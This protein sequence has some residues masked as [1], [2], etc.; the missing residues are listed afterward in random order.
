LNYGKK[1]KGKRLDEIPVDYLEW[2]MKDGP[3]V[4]QDLRQTIEDFLRPQNRKPHDEDGEIQPRKKNKR[5][6]EQTPEDPILQRAEENKQKNQ[7]AILDPEWCG[8]T[9]E[10]QS[11]K[12]LAEKINQEHIQVETALRSGLEHARRA[13]EYLLRARE[14]CRHGE[15]LSWLA[16][17]VQFSE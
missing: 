10:P 3:G 6:K 15:W 8:A 12:S 16:A 13:G 7:P 9:S 11:L 17:H 4:S 5:H 14:Q 2:V 1:H